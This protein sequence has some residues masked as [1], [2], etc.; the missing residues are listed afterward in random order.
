MMGKRKT[1]T[2]GI[3]YWDKKLWKVFSRY[4][5]LRDS[6]RTT[7]GDLDS[8]GNPLIYCITCDHMYPIQQMQAGHWIPR[9]HWSTRYH[10]A[11]V[12]AQCARCNKWGGGEP[13]IYEDKIIAIYGKDIKAELKS[14]MHEIRKYKPYELEEMYHEYRDAVK[15]LE[16]ELGI[17]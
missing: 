12:N 9:G 5:R 15:A 17:S 13:Q 10:E 11:N 14:T 2:K 1:K 7:G 6:L 8:E 16:E 3:Q 4:I